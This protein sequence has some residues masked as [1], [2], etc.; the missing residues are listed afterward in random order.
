MSAKAKKQDLTVGNPGT[1]LV[2]FTFPLLISAVFQQLYNIA[3]SII[4]GRF[5]GKEALAAVG[6]SYP[7]TMLFVAAALGLC[8]GSS[9]VI[10]R[11]YGAREYA[12][13]KT[14]AFTAIIS[15]LV[16]SLVMS[17]V[18]FVLGTPLLR[19]MKTEQT[20]MSDAAAYLNIYLLGVVFL[21]LYNICTGIFTALGDSITP[22]ILLVISS[23]GNVVLDCVFII[24]FKTGVR[25]AAWAT[26]LCQAI[27]SVIAFFILMRRLS[28]IKTEKPYKL[29]SRD[30]LRQINR[31]SIPSMLQQSFVSVGNLFIQGFVNSFG[32]NVLAGYQSAIKLNTFT[33]TMMGTMS[34]AASSFTAQNLG[35]G[36]I[37]RVKQGFKSS[38]TIMCVTAVFMSVLFVVFAPQIAGLFLDSGDA[39]NAEALRIGT[40]FLRIVS[41]AFFIVATKLCCDGVLKGGGAMKEF[42]MGTFTDLLLRVALSFVLSM[43]F[44]ET[45]IWM[46]WPIGW[47][48]AACMSFF[49]YKKGK[50]ILTNRE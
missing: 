10:A 11:N 12:D 40:R 38:L 33:V 50:W 19:L 14:A 5:C 39:D 16:F 8:T 31:I 20:I 13:T 24:C 3:D 25:G 7:V 2:K 21:F 6:A 49:F 17:L 23:L 48:I 43:F 28:G 15:A 9:V 34:N 26:F 27:C 46:S 41:P 37:S 45:G 42:M 1:V 22:L 47:F 18:G 29:F 30:M 35:A 44:D 4:V 36:K 32:V